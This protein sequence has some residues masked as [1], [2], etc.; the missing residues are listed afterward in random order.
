MLGEKITDSEP[1]SLLLLHL[2]DIH[3][4]EPYCLNLETDQDH[5]IRTAMLNDLRYMVCRIGKV[6]AILVSGDIA[7]KGNQEE[8]NVAAG[9]FSEIT[10]IAGCSKSDIYTVPGNHDVNRTIAGN[11]TVKAA[12]NFILNNSPT[13]AARDRK[14]HDTLLNGQLGP[15]LVSPM[16]KYNLFAA[17]FRCDFSANVPF[18]IQ[19]LPLAPGW[20]LKMHGLTTTLFSGPEDDLRGTLYVGALQHAFAPNDGIIHLAMMHHPPEWLYDN[21]ALDDDLWNCCALHLLGHKHRQRYRTGTNGVRLVAGAVNPSRG[22]DE[23][24]PGY[25]LI[26]LQVAL[27]NS[28][29]SLKIE[30]YRRVWQADPPRFVA[31]KTDDD[32]EVFIHTVALRQQPM[33]TIRKQIEQIDEPIPPT[34]VSVLVDELVEVS[35]MSEPQRDLVY[36]FWELTPSQ[37]RKIMQD[38]HLLDSTDDQLPETQRYRLAFER[39]RDRARI[40]ELKT[41]VLKLSA[42]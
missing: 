39:A 4:Q 3:F 42:Q 17:S 10:S 21:D 34:R 31:I 41:E 23:W 32:K 33:Q 18:W 19:T 14:L 30:S 27:N 35:D 24:L 9:W 20:Q 26:K 16:E 25:N 22:E 37:R 28:Q 8:Y 29:Y 40:D 6:N 5:P 38:L 11:L 2:S 7:Y 12:R 13:G 36:A 15:D 1:D